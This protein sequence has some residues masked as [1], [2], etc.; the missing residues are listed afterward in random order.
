MLISIDASV[1]EIKT[2]RDATVGT[3][4]EELTKELSEEYADAIK[5]QSEDALERKEAG[6]RYNPAHILP[7][8]AELLTAEWEKRTGAAHRDQNDATQDIPT[9][10]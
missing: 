4:S 3:V 8:T 7:T 6:R 5:R 2:L 1:E 10:I 9:I